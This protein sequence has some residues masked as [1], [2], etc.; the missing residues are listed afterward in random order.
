METTRLGGFDRIVVL[1]LVAG[2]AAV[3]CGAGCSAD[4]DPAAAHPPGLSAGG[5]A[6]AE[7]Q[8]IPV[9]VTAVRR[10]DLTHY[11]AV[12][13][14]VR[15][16][17]L[18]ELESETGGVVVE[19]PAGEG[20][21]AA[22]GD[23]LV[24]FD[25]RDAKLSLQRAAADRQSALVQYAVRTLDQGGVATGFWQAGA[26]PAIGLDEAEARYAE[27]LISRRDLDAVRRAHDL[28]GLGEPAQ[29]DRSIRADVGLSA[30]EVA[31]AEAE[32]RIARCEVRAPFAGTV[33]EMAL[34]LG[35]VVNA[36]ELLLTLVDLDDVEIV[37]EVL[38]TD[39]MDLRPGARASV[40]PTTDPNRR[41]D[42]RILRISPLV[43]ATR[44]VGRVTLS[45][46]PGRIGLRSGAH[47][48]VSMEG[49]TLR[50]RLIVPNDAVLYS[51]DRPL[52]M[53][54]RD[55]V[56]QWEYVQLG[57]TNGDDTEILPDEAALRGV[58]P[59]EL[60]VTDGNFTLAH[61]TPVTVT[62]PERR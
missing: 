53:V 14:E 28:G 61:D 56:A 29:R 44:R 50:D 26:R 41:L 24:R 45:V 42:A 51:D 30:A 25:C 22:A 60:V 40:E 2:T 11:V 17:N 7:Q 6:A 27:G 4:P 54:V 8:A 59:G 10:G 49:R 20:T 5:A 12:D 33:A 31:I 13:G 43:D 21:R 52:V 46:S 16:R 55:G 19:L 3:A 9:T 18:L 36:G 35:Q 37:A 23:V 38:E 58:A 47:V 32:L 15:A 34:Q 57:E 48:R 1:L 39:L 62:E